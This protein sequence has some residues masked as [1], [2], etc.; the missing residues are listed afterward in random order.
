VHAGGRERSRAISRTAAAAGAAVETI[1]PPRPKC[2]SVTARAVVV[3]PSI[4]VTR[5]WCTETVWFDGGAASRAAAATSSAGGPISARRR[6]STAGASDRRKLAC[7]QPKL[8]PNVASSE[9]RV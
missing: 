1:D 4:P 9:C 5:T 7:R 3:A 6:S 2:G 8:G